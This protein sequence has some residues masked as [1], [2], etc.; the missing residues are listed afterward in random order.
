MLTSPDART[1]TLSATDT[2]C[3][4]IPQFLFL[5]TLTLSHSPLL[6]LTSLLLYT[7]YALNIRVLLKFMC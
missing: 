7:C 1:G 2:T 6:T 3:I 4:P 5:F